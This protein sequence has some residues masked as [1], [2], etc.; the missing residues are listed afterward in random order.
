MARSNVKRIT[1]IKNSFSKVLNI[2]ITNY[3]PILSHTH[4]H[5]FKTVTQKSTRIFVT[6]FFKV[7]RRLKK[8]EYFLTI[9]YTKC[10][11]HI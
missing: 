3:P 5:T 9:E 10:G 7:A 1:S 6:A 11:I 2:E 4:T 8:F